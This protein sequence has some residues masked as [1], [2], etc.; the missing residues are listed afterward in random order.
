MGIRG[1]F[2]GEFNLYFYTVCVCVYIYIYIIRG[3]GS[4]VGIANDYG[5]NGPGIESKWGV[6]FSAPVQTSHGAD[7]ASY[8]RVPD[9]SRG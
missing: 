4:S 7:Q 6:R 9:L 8:I 3:S 1:L 5:P 2:Y